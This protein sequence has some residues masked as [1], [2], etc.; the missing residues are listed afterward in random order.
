MSTV[1]S[2]TEGRTGTRSRRSRS[3]RAV[4]S[5]S[6]ATATIVFRKKCAHQEE[7]D[8]N[9][10]TTSPKV[11]ARFLVLVNE[12][13]NQTLKEEEYHDDDARQMKC[14]SQWLT[15]VRFLLRLAIHVC[16]LS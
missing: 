8:K 13:I 11:N 14:L 16:R 1:V 6:F 5:F 15:H 3:G 4:S 10:S 2:S 7:D 12:H 9:E